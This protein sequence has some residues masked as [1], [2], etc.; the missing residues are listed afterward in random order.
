MQTPVTIVRFPP[1]VPQIAIEST[2]N[3]FNCDSST[4]MLAE[5]VFLR[6]RDISQGML[7]WDRCCRNLQTRTQDQH[8]LSDQCQHHNVDR[9]SKS[10]KTSAG[11]K[12]SKVKSDLLLTKKPFIDSTCRHPCNLLISIRLPSEIA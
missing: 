7:P 9:L 2:I 5:I 6:H 3:P 8:H 12:D 10:S 4:T 11:S 1:D